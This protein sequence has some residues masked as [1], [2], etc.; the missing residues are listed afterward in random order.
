MRDAFK[1]FRARS[2]TIAVVVHD[3]RE[4]VAAFWAKRELPYV[5]LP[6]PDGV[7]AKAYGQPWRL[8]KLGRMPALFIIDRQ[9]RLV[10]S[11]RG[12]SMKDIPPI[13]AVLGALDRV[14]AAR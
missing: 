9:R 2:A 1:D 14:N 7:I 6:D 3:S 11:H 10:V 13:K 8:L 5:G 12:T 4:H